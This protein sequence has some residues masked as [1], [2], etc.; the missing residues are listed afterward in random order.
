MSVH[1]LERTLLDYTDDMLAVLDT[2]LRFQAVNAAYRSMFGQ[3][4]EFFIGRTIREVFGHDVTHYDANIHPLLEQCLQGET[5]RFERWVDVPGFGDLY[6]EICYTPFFDADNQLVGIVVVGHNRTEVMRSIEALQRSEAMLKRTEHIAN[7]GGWRLEVKNARMQWTDEMYRI[8][9]VEP[10][11]LPS[12]DNIGG[13]IID[14]DQKRFQKWIEDIFEQRKPADI[15][16]RLMT[17]KGGS[18]WVRSIAFPNVVEGDVVTVEGV[19]QDVTELTRIQEQLSQ[20]EEKYR[21]LVEETNAMVWEARLNVRRFDYMSPQAEEMTG[22]SSEQW[23]SE[24]FLFT[25][26]HPEDLPMAMEVSAQAISQLKDFAVEYRLVKADG[27]LMWLHD[28]VKVIQDE[29]GR[30]L[31]LRGVMID[32]TVMK[33]M[34]LGLNRALQSLESHKAVLD[35]HAILATTDK[36]GL[37]REVNDKFIELFGYSRDEL[38]GQPHSIIRSYVH[39]ES[40]YQNMWDT[41]FSGQVWQGELCNRGKNGQLFWVY[42]TIVPMLDENREIEY[43]MS[44]STD[45]S[46]VKQAEESLRR[47]Q[48]MEAIGQLTGGVAHDFNN[49][50]GIV[51][52][53][54]ELLEQAFPDNERVLT[55]LENA[56]NAALRGSV[57]TRRMLNFSRQTPVQAE[58]LDI[59][60]V[61]QGLDV[62]IS[63][64][65]TARVDMEMDLAEGLWPVEADA[66]DFEDVMINLSINASDAMPQGG[67]LTFRSRNVDSKRMDSAHASEI[68][69]GQYV[70]IT[71]EDTGTGMEPEVLDKIFD[72]YFSTKP[73]DKGTGLGLAM[74]YGF[75]QRSKGFIFVDSRLGEGTRFTLY[76]PRSLQPGQV[77]KTSERKDVPETTLQGGKET[78]LLVDDEEDILATT[79]IGL[80]MLGYRILTCSSGDEAIE[81]LKQSPD[82]IDLLFTDVV[83]PGKLNG[84]EL[85]E[86]ALKLRPDLKLLFTT[87][88]AR[89][90]ENAATGAWKEEWEDAIIPKP[91][92]R[93]ELSRRIRETLDQT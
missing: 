11:F 19:L 90:E 39:P 79:R 66:G 69:P 83:M 32:V 74:V 62:L 18:K 57:L 60:A 1:D 72:P 24:G 7:L 64:S 49:L 5:S 10:D 21:S 91:Y 40:F 30:P 77:H 73:S 75:V 80:E 78:I 3:P 84:F 52:G 14:E 88:Y 8:H 61:M 81:V 55:Q 16:C 34:Q 47:V 48:K 63:K 65:L 23:C 38:I 17:A 85:A 86:A 58:A 93:S 2:E 22:Y 27:S 50:L 56:K 15:V 71:V 53:N 44:V 13:F 9:E 26:I 87:G 89:L 29:E 54:I 33:D 37:I 59:N 25:R 45:I 82:N 68:P 92:R 20:N 35:K 42:T 76:L 6:L 36:T 51:I 43:F 70:E 4:R 46:D 12:P 67:R 28:N 31:K 41:I